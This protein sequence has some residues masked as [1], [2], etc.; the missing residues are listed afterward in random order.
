[1]LHLFLVWLVLLF[2]EDHNESLVKEN[3]L[4]FVEDSLC[5]ENPVNPNP[6]EGVEGNEDVWE[7]CEPG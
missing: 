5:E 4:C 1:M 7:G 3:D 6:A 2:G